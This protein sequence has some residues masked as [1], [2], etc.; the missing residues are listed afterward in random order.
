MS[1]SETSRKTLLNMARKAIEYKIKGAQ[2]KLDDTEANELPDELKEKRAVF[3]TL[4]KKTELRGCIG[5]LEPTQEIYKDVIENAISAG[6]GDPR[7]SSVTEKELKDIVIEI[8]ILS[9]PEK[10]EYNTIDELLNSIIPGKHGLIIKKGF[11]GAT[12]LP[13]VWEQLPNKE[14]FFTNLCAKAGMYPE[15]WKNGKL[16]VETYEVENFKE[17]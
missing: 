7:F 5:H 9:L 15:E 13:Q 6:F 2:Y 14:N 4:T 17:E 1:I 10:I 16:E 3:V 11:K 12:F 8:S